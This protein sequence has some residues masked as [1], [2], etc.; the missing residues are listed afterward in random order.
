MHHSNISFPYF[1][2]IYFYIFYVLDNLA[3]LL[4]EIH[5]NINHENVKIF[6]KWFVGTHF[7]VVSI[8]DIEII[9][10]SDGIELCLRTGVI[11]IAVVVIIIVILRALLTS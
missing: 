6:V 5:P 1:D 2:C 8:P 7:D 3:A 9:G 10:A 11:A 4:N